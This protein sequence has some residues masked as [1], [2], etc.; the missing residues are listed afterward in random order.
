MEEKKH[1]KNER[2]RIRTLR[3]MSIYALLMLLMVIFALSLPKR[4]EVPAPQT[5]EQSVLAETEYVYVKIEQETQETEFDTEEQ[6][7]T[8][9]EHMDKIG[10]FTADGTLYTVIDVYVKTL[11]EADRRLLE[12][13]IEIVGKKQLGQLIEDYS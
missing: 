3:L 6:I 7:Y 13:G 9:R 5:D 2:S 4:S 12:E 11:P 10:I 1:S 8:V